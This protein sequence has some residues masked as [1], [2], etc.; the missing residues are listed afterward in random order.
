[1]VGEF[2]SVLSRVKQQQENVLFLHCTCHVA[3]LAASHA[4][5]E[6][7]D[8]YEQ[9]SKDVYAHFKTTGKRKAEFKNIQELMDVVCHDIFDL[10]LRDG[11]QFCSV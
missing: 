6:L 11:W 9:L 4:C 2:N 10:T 1:M 5:S 8:V 3:H 7:P